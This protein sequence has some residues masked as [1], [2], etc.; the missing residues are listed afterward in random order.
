MRDTNDAYWCLRWRPDEQNPSLAFSGSA[1]LE[2]SGSATDVLAIF[3]GYL[4][5]KDRLRRRQGLSP[6]CTEADI[7]AAAYRKG[8]LP[9]VTASLRGG[10]VFALWD[11]AQKR[12]IVSRDAVGLRPCFYFWDG[13]CFILSSSL[14]AVLAQPEV[15]LGFNRAVIAEYLLGISTKHQRVE[16]F[17]EDVVRL[18]PAHWLSLSGKELRTSRYWDPVPVGFDW[19]SDE[20]LEQFQPFLERAVTRCLSAGA[21]SIALSGGFDSVGIAALASEQLQGKAPLSALSLRFDDALCDEGPT[22]IEVA[23][24]LGMP[25]LIRTLE[26]S[27]GGRSVLAASLDL[28]EISP[29][30]VLSIWQAFYT[31]LLGSAPPHCRHLLMG[32]GGDD[33]LNVDLRYAGDCLVSLQLRRLWQF[34]RTCQ[35]TSPFSAGLVARVVLWDNAI[36]PEARELA[37]RILNKLV[38]GGKEWLRAR[39]WKSPY[40]LLTDEALVTVLAERRRGSARVELG[41]G[42]RSYVAAIR[43]ILQS[44]LLLQEFEQGFAWAQSLGF[45]LLFPYFDQ[46]LAELLLRIHPQHLL[47]GGRAKAPLRRLVAERLPSVTLPSKKVDFGQIVHTLLRPHCEAQWKE[48]GEGKTLAKLG[49]SNAERLGSAVHDYAVG[50]SQNSH[51]AWRI[52]STE[53]WLRKR[54]ARANLQNRG[55]STHPRGEPELVR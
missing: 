55:L 54:A 15:S 51:M 28:S 5:E 47:S 52:L 18:P 26:E 50:Q 35:R 25:Q 44:P 39:V 29:S 21:D 24:R 20:E 36:K 42:E 27:I 7:I 43:G 8:E 10:F 48:M 3:D 4:V 17:Y 37:S 30:P 16:T 46:D 32:T 33:L 11:A 12:L 40:R 6:P 1:S 13:R 31:G 34:L 41:S 38:P 14:D 2:V 53:A 45:T 9:E 49:V 19:A 23:R 22:Q